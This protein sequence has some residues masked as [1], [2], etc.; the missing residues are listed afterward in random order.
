MISSVSPFWLR[1]INRR[2]KE[3]TY[4][5]GYQKGDGENLLLE[6]RDGAVLLQ[7]VEGCGGVPQLMKVGRFHTAPLFTFTII[8]KLR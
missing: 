2:R 8:R 3:V 4:E 6:L 5:K 7:I 1:R